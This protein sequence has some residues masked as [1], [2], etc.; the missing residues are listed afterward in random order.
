M[1]TAFAD[2]DEEIYV[3]LPRGAR[4]I[5][6]PTSV[7]PGATVS[8]R[9][10]KKALIKH[11]GYEHVPGGKGSHVKLVKLNSPM[12]ILRGNRPVVSPGVVKQALN[13]V[14][15]Y[16]ISRLPDFLEGRL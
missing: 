7:D 16:P 8:S 1:I 3:V 15:G 4:P 14:G 10:L 9:N 5:F 12:I 13:A 2:I 11:H 6:Q